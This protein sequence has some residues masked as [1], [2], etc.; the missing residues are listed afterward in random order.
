MTNYFYV[1]QGYYNHTDTTEP[2]MMTKIREALKSIDLMPE[3]IYLLN[4]EQRVSELEKQNAKRER[5]P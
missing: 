1:I 4:Y 3:K 5:M 2:E